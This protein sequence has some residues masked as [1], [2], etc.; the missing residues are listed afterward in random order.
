[1]LSKKEIT[2]IVYARLFGLAYKPVQKAFTRTFRKPASTRI[3]FKYLVNK[4]KRTGSV[5]YNDCSNILPITLI[6]QAIQEGVTHRTV[7]STQ[8]FS[9]PAARSSEFFQLENFTLSFLISTQ[10][11]TFQI[12]FKIGSEY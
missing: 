9:Q 10:M 8:K 7:S 3:A 5:K 1:M 6:L 11:T 12:M 4:F 2:D